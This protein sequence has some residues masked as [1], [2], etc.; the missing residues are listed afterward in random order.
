[1]YKR[2]LAAV[3]GSPNSYRA[4]ERAAI[5]A[6]TQN[7]ELV[8]ANVEPRQ[9]VPESLRQFARVEH[10]DEGA[11]ETW[12][13][14][15]RAVLHRASS[16]ATEAAGGELKIREETMIGDPADAI[17]DAADAE[18]PDLIV[19]GNRG[20]SQIKGLILGSVSQKLAANAHVD[21][22]IVK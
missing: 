6:K 3:D 12:E 4:V 15:A 10:L 18:N 8:L 19:V 11:T 1:M 9:P 5:I 21:V 2:I 22:L 13:N 17:L 16:E 14:I 7:A 20:F